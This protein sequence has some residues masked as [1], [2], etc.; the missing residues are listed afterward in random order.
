MPA[1]T[2][3]RIRGACAGVE[4]AMTTASGP[5]P[6]TSSIFPASAPTSLATASALFWS[7][8]P[9][10]SSLTPGSRESTPA[11][12][13]PIRPA[14][15]SP[16]FIRILS[17]LYAEQRAELLLSDLQV[18]WGVLFSDERETRVDLG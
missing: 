12:R 6:S 2:E 8:S 5:A 18:A 11:W 16:T 9:T 3:A 17:V 14:P 15:S 4:A 1:S 10:S 7:A 13:V